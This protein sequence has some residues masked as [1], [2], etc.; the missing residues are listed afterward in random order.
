MV[1]LSQ[2]ASHARRL[3]PIHPVAIP[4]SCSITL[5]SD[6]FVVSGHFYRDLYAIVS[7]M[8]S[9]V[10]VYDS[11]TASQKTAMISALFAPRKL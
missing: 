2:Y 3:S 7:L 1:M 6:L 9:I 8:S 4:N 5:A 11:T 10:L